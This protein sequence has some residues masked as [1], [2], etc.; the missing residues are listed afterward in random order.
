ML[1]AAGFDNVDVIELMDGGKLRI[2]LAFEQ[3]ENF[4]RIE[5]TS[6]VLDAISTAAEEH[7]WQLLTISARWDK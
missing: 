7:D 3:P 1:T 2:V 5:M 4:T 6:A